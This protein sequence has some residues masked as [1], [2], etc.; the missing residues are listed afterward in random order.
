MFRLVGCVPMCRRGWWI[1][2]PRSYQQHLNLLACS[3]QANSDLGFG[4]QV[5]SGTH[6]DW[7]FAYNANKYTIKNIRA[8]V[9]RDP[10]LWV[11]QAACSYD[12][13]INARCRDATNSFRMNNCCDGGGC[14]FRTVSTCTEYLVFFSAMAVYAVAAVMC[15]VIVVRLCGMVVTPPPLYC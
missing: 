5:G 1:T 8:Y 15:D 12:S 6:P 14:E 7:T 3:P 10:G 2:A 9:S 4:A 11:P 13:D